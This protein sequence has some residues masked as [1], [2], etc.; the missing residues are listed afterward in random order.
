MVRW[1]RNTLGVALST[2]AFS[3]TPLS[4]PIIF[5]SK[6]QGVEQQARDETFCYGWAKNYTGFD[7]AQALAELHAQQE[8]ALRQT[9]QVQQAA[10]QQ[11][12]AAVGAPARGGVGGA[13]AGA[14]IGAVA[15]NA[16]R[17][18]A[19]GATT[20]VLAG[21][22]ARR[23]HA[24]AVAQQQEQQQAQITSQQAQLQA[25]TQQKLGEYNRASQT[26]MQGKGYAIS[27]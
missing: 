13:A 17:G 18:A 6:G 2:G 24:L 19:I 16:G 20:G 1:S 22:A 15:G 11:A 23:Q 14:A 4:R 8:R 26:C 25:A 27:Y 9:Q 10:Q 5:P 7:P 12:N 21:A 3:Q